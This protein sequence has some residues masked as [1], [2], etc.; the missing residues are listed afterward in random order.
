MGILNKLLFFL[1]NGYFPRRRLQEQI[2]AEVIE[3][4]PNIYVLGS[5]FHDNLKYIAG[6]IAECV[7]LWKTPPEDINDILSDIVALNL[8]WDPLSVE[9]KP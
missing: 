6:I 3:N 7:I 2:M 5:D 1:T 8:K 9:E 4:D